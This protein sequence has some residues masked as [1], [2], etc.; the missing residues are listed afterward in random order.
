MAIR[1]FNIKE[2]PEMN[3]I[4]VKADTEKY[5]KKTLESFSAEGVFFEKI[6][7]DERYAHFKLIEGDNYVLR[8]KSADATTIGANPTLL[9]KGKGIIAHVCLDDLG[10]IRLYNKKKSL[11]LK[12]ISK[13]KAY[14]LKRDSRNWKMFQS[15]V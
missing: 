5:M 2:K 15:W 14:S 6:R 8:D 12:E 10:N 4:A 1:Y 7:E 9:N 13:S 11:L 3:G